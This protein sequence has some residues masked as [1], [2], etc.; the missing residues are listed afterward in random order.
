M[1]YSLIIPIFNEDR[2]LKKLLNN[3]E[4]LSE[5]IEIIIIDDGSTDSTN[6]ILK[7]YS[8]PKIKVKT[9]KSNSGKGIAIRKGVEIAKHQ[10][11]ILFDGDLEINVTEIPKLIN[12]YDEEKCDALVGIRWEENKK[13]VFDINRLG[14]YLVNFI[15]NLLYKSKSNDVLCCLKI[16]KTDLFNSLKIRSEEFNIEVETMAKL[17]K[18]K[19][20]IKEVKI[21][22]KRRTIEEGKK[23][24]LIH[25][26][27]IFWTMLKVKFLFKP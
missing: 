25:G 11:I 26:F 15:F 19:S 7:N 1:N 21:K 3:L 9:N 20:K 22:Y 27:S 2:T 8:I 5:N 10:N 4:N 16:L 12:I 14:N 6:N 24:K 23:I 18:K 13:T 17:V